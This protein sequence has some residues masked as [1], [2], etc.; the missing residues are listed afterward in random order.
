MAAEPTIYQVASAAGVSISTVSLA[1]NHPERVRPETLRRVLAVADEIGFTPKERAVIR[2]RRGL[3]RIAAVGPFS[4]YPSYQRRLAGALAEIA[5]APSE[6]VVHDYED[7]AVSGSPL[8]STLPVRGQVDG[9]VIMGVEVD[10]EVARRLADRLP[11]V[12]LDVRHELLPSVLVDDLAA[13][14]EVGELFRARGHRRVAFVGEVEATP[15]AASPVDRRLQGLRAGFG[16]E[17]VDSYLLPR[18]EDA[19]EGAVDAILAAPAAD[20]PTAVFAYRDMVG[21]RLLRA[22]RRRG[23]RLPE[24][25]E[26][27]GYDDEEAAAATGLSSVAHP[28]EESGRHAVRLLRE[29]VAHPERTHSSLQLAYRL[30]ER[31]TT[32]G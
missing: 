6:L 4:S 30:V 21:L 17:G 11:T 26:L 28:F 9:V 23:V 3:G 31:D 25:I 7:V 29:M 32:R 5:G 10:D 13:A 15:F 20:R 27:I 8:L 12:L 14:R 2:A 19:A 24:E 1:V 16:E 18:T 22:L